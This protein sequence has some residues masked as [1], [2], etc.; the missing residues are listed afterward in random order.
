MSDPSY[1]DFAARVVESGIVTD[2]WIRGKP[3][4]AEKPLILTAREQTALYRAT[5]QVAGVYNDVCRMCADDPELL[6]SFF[7]LTPFQ[8]AMW[9]SSRPMWHGIARADVFE[10]DEGLAF[11]EL[12]SD[13][14]TG[15]AEA[16]VLNQAAHPDHPDTLDPNAALGATYC[17]MV[18]G[19]ARFTLGE[20]HPRVAGI[21]YPTELT[22]DLGVIRLFKRWFEERGWDVV[23]GSPY[24]LTLD[25]EGR[26]C[27]FDVPFSVMLRHYKTDWWGERV[28][29]WDDESLPDTEP[30]REPLGV[31][32][33]AALGGKL[34]IVNPFGAVLPQNKRTMALMWEHI[35]RFGPAAQEV[36]RRFI[37][38]TFRLETLEPKVVAA[39]KDDWVLKS[40][41][42][43]EGEEVIIGKQATPEIWQKS[44]EHARSGHWVAQRYFEAR[45]NADGEVVNYG[46]Y[47]VAGNAAG[48]YSRKHKG[49]T[50][51]EALSVATLVQP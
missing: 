30:L 23:L 43:A 40:D 51:D 20:G 13:T 14:P 24:N 26:A 27:L 38:A 10:T 42:G 12:N 9:E 25:A 4:L 33:A 41:Y 29:A 22:E 16:V 6:D 46:V 5:E 44:L 34:C 2:P 39:E 17:E 28:S 35:H 37:P 8:K 11:A 18:E 1:D 15:E 47:L 49:A 19:L 31:A 32:L 48:L 7:R 36:I 21:V 45:A 50:T 3:R